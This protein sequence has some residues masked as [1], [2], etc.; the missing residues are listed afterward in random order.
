M[1]KTTVL[2]GPITNLTDARYFAAREAKWLLFDFEPTSET[3]L[4]PQ[5]MSAIR[6]W[7]DG[8]KIVGAF[9]LTE[10]Y[11]IR[12][13]IAK[14]Q[15]DAIQLGMLTP[16]ETVIELQAN[17]PVFKEIVI[18]RTTNFENLMS[19]L[20]SWQPFV[21]FFVLNFYKNGISWGQLNDSDLLSVHTLTKLLQNFPIVLG[22]DLQLEVLKGMEDMLLFSGLYVKGEAE[23]KIGYKSF[24]ELDAIFDLLEA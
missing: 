14:W 9:E 20:E 17:V 16:V 10:A 7:V 21:Q 18:E 15:L 11:E 1:L 13:N 12:E 3:Y 2:A 4:D 23:E 6:E 19:I 5:K 24:E 22:I 8:V